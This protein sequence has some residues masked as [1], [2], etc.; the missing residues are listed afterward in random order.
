M[1]IA[2]ENRLVAR[3]F[4]LTGVT[5]EVTTYAFLED[6]I[7]GAYARNRAAGKGFAA[8]Y[9]E[10]DA[11]RSRNESVVGAKTDTSRTAPASA[12]AA[13]AIIAGF[14]LLLTAAAIVY[15]IVGG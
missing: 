11:D 3:L 7:R 2:L 15:G 13:T 12:K 4:E 8:A 5:R 14:F 1:A 9:S 6:A 10:A